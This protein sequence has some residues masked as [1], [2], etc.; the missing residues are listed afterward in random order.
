MAYS[1]SIQENRRLRGIQNLSNVAE[2]M[3]CVPFGPKEAQALSRD[4]SEGVC[5]VWAAPQAR[6]CIR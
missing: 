4:A 3:E 6:L 2:R 5:L 1:A